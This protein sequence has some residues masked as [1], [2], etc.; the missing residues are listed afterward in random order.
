MRDRLPLK[1]GLPFCLLFVDDKSLFQPLFFHN[2]SIYQVFQKV[3]LFKK[4][5]MM[6]CQ[7]IDKIFFLTGCF[8]VPPKYS[9]KIV[10]VVINRVKNCALKTTY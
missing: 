1:H 5:P 4:W 6:G 8:S 10:F 9:K 3:L 7:I 2:L